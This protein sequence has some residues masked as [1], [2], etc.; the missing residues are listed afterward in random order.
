VRALRLLTLAAGLAALA[1]A[2]GSSLAERQA[3]TV[4]AKAVGAGLANTCAL[5]RAGGVECWGYNGDDELGDGHAADRSTPVAVSGLASGV[6]A[7]A[8]GLRNACAI[9][10]GGSVECWGASYFGALGDGTTT[11]HRTPVAVAGLGTGVKA[12]SAGSDDGCAVTGSGGVKCWGDNLRGQLGDGTT[13]DRAT[14][15]TCRGWR[16]V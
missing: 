6:T 16:A 9:T 3:A 7:I 14:P 5:T 2:A 10:R 13:A 8:E 4:P 1:V 12:I 15:S 11:P